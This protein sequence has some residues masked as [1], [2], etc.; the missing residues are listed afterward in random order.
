MNEAIEALL[1]KSQ[2]KLTPIEKCA[3]HL[4]LEGKEED[5]TDVLGQLLALQ[6]TVAQLTD[7]LNKTQEAQC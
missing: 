6:D 4:W 5:A 3:R 2:R 7:K 1:K